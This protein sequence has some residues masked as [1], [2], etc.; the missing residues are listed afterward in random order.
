MRDEILRVGRELMQTRSFQG[1]SFQDIADRVGIRK[2]SLYHHFPSKDAL[3]AAVMNEMTQRFQ[4]WAEARRG[5]PRQQ[6]QAYLD[7]VRDIIGAGRCMCPAGS[8]VGGWGCMSDELRQAVADLRGRQVDWMTEV[9]R[10]LDALPVPP[11]QMAACFFAV[12]QGG[13]LSARI[14]GRLEDFDDAVAP[15]RAQL[16]LKSSKAA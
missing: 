16:G 12:S 6:L 13:L 15:V 7:M 8:S 10:G 9:M 4:R 14:S 1:F 2:A 3:G 5:T 11:D